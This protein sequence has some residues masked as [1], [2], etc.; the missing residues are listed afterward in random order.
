M[1]HRGHVLSGRSAAPRRGDSAGQPPD[2]AAADAWPGAAD[3][4]RVGT[5]VTTMSTSL[6]SLA[7]LV[8]AFNPV[9]P[10]LR[11]AALIV[12]R[13]R[14]LLVEH[15]KR[16]Q[17]Y[18]VLPGGRLQGNET[19]DAALQ[20]ELH[21][22]LGLEARVGRLVIV[23]ETLAPDRHMVNLI[24]QVEIGEKA[25]PRLDRSDP[26]LAGWQ[27]VSVDQLPRLDF[28]PPIAAAVLD[29]IAENFSG[30]VRMLGDTWKPEPR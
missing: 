14:I 5:L 22:E 28:R 17:R 16:D 27:W 20:R 12:Q 21:E 2:L 13:G 1:E 4:A 24:Y 30:P 10:Q 6:V 23:C 26:V 3:S 8:N 19:L 18:W 7:A 29:V 15:R 11:V 9:T 25:E